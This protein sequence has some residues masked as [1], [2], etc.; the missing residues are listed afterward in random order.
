[1]TGV[2]LVIPYGSLSRK[3]GSGVPFFQ[4][5]KHYVS[6]S[7]PDFV[8][9]H[10]NYRNLIR[11]IPLWLGLSWAYAHYYTDYEHILDENYDTGKIKIVN[12]M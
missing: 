11:Q 5:P 8:F 6:T 4:R 2:L 12:K 1:L 10:R 3:L 9:Q 7:R